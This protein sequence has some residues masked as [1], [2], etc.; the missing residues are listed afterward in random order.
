MRKLI[1]LFAVLVICSILSPQFAVAADAVEGLKTKRL[2]M[3]GQ[4][5][6]GHPWSTHEYMSGLGI[7]AK[8]LQD[9]PGLQMV[10]ERADEPW[11]RGPELID[12][13]DGIVVFLSQG[14]KWIQ[15]DPARLAAFQAFQA[16]GGSL[17]VLHWGM[18]CVE[19]RYIDA[20]VKLFGGCHGGPDRKHKVVRVRAEAASSD[21]PIVNGIGGFDVEEEFYY[22]LKFVKPAGT[23]TP[24]LKV[25]IDG[26]T[27]T[28]AWSWQR[29]DGGRSFGFSGGHF[30]RNWKLPEYRR[31]VS[32][33]ILWTLDLPVP[34]AGLPV[35]VA[36][37][38]LVL[39]E[40][41]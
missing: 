8:C 3:L 24:L 27:E 35:N 37:K 19:A 6:D 36:P 33:G 40:R 5:P 32:Q 30:H 13:A 4:S 16:R 11:E 26:N 1:R 23:V 41:K 2:L 31:L 29:S 17:V 34:P 15:Q 18:G 7:L 28:V 38:D 20:F 10:I 25:S 12:G 21:H 9:V 22:A 39:P 14:A